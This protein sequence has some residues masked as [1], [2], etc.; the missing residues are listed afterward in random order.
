MGNAQSIIFTP[1][2]TSPFSALHRQQHLLAQGH[3]SQ[4]NSSLDVLSSGS[5]SSVRDRKASGKS[6]LSTPSAS[7]SLGPGTAPTGFYRQ[8]SSS[9]L[10]CVTS[11]FLV[12]FRH[13]D[14]R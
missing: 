3:A 8:Q 12:F 9:S 7:L 4:A 14:F 6:V 13:L 10:I 1:M 5:S 11:F 2:T